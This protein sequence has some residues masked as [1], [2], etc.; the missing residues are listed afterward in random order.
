MSPS[1][2]PDAG[3]LAGVLR[4]AADVLN[5]KAQIREQIKALRHED[6]Q[7]TAEIR[8]TWGARVN[9]MQAMLQGFV[10]SLPALP[11]LEPV[12]VE[13]VEPQPE[14]VPVIIDAS[15]SVASSDGVGI[16]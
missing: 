2:T 4:H 6:D 14:P 16:S 8:A 7:L 15:D 9:E 5:R 13:P 12:V 10:T 11:D 3:D 1:A